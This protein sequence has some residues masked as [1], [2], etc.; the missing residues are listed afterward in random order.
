MQKKGRDIV[1]FYCF[2]YLIINISGA[3]NTDINF[4]SSLKHLDSILNFISDFWLN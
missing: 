3:I 2:Y 4:F 1:H